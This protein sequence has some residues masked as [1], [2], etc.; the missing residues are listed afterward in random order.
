MAIDDR[1]PVV[2]ILGCDLAGWVRTEGTDLIIEG[3]RMIDHLCLIQILIQELHDLV[4][5]LDPHANVYSTD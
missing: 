1:K 4:P 5:H 3:L 2:I